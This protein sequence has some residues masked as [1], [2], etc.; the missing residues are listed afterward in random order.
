MTQQVTIWR[1]L[2]AGPFFCALLMIG[3]GCATTPGEEDDDVIDSAEKAEEEVGEETAAVDPD[4]G[5]EEN[6]D[7]Q[8][9]DE[10]VDEFAETSD[11]DEDVAEIPETVDYSLGGECS[12]PDCM[13]ATGSS[14]AAAGKPSVDDWKPDNNSP[15]PVPT[16]QRD[17]QLV[18]QQ[19]GPGLEPGFRRFGCNSVR[20]TD[21]H[22]YGIVKGWW[23]IKRADGLRAK[24][25]SLNFR[26]SGFDMAFDV[27]ETDATYGI[28]VI[29]GVG[30]NQ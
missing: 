24:S 28:K 9:G 20:K 15:A 22:H 12:D 4:T 3:T 25:K 23:E 29:P 5:M 18:C 2:I 13:E 11:K 19:M 16:N 7:D 1:L 6:E 30:E 8:D 26:E 21:G 27:L 14:S 17:L 10:E